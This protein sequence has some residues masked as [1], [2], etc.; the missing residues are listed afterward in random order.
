MTRTIISTIPSSNDHTSETTIL[1]S[2]RSCNDISQLYWG[3]T[4]ESLELNQ[5]APQRRCASCMPT[6]LFQQLLKLKVLNVPPRRKKAS[7]SVRSK[8]KN[9]LGLQPEG[10]PRSRIT[11]KE[12]AAQLARLTAAGGPRRCCLSVFSSRRRNGNQRSR[13]GENKP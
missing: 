9:A 5:R 7:G 13:I 1:A 6:S 12:A 10:V 4:S 8:T 2:S 11:G 3:A